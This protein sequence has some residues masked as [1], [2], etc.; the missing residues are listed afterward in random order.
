MTSVISFNP[1]QA[2]KATAAQAALEM[3]DQAYAYY[4]PEPRHQKT[5]PDQQQPDAELFAYYRAA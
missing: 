4:M 1:A 3:L 5:T 2:S